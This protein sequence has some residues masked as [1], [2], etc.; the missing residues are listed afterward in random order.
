MNKTHFTK[1]GKPLIQTQNWIYYSKSKI[2]KVMFASTC[3][4]L[5]VRIGQWQHGI[6]VIILYI[7]SLSTD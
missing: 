6:E 7:N 4:N 2:S 3:S 5:R 1:I